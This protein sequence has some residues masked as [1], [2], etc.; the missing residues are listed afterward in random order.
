ME[1]EFTLFV[2]DDA[3]AVRRMI[4]SVFGK[5]YT[6]ESFASGAACLERLA[7]KVPGLFL[8]DVDMPEM[9]GYT[10]CRQIKDQPV[11]ANIPVIFISALD[12]LESRLAGYDAGGEE[13]IVKPY[14]VAELKKKIEVLRRI[15]QEKSALLSKL[16]E[17]D[18]LTS[19]VMSSLDE[20][21]ILVKFLRSLNRCAKYSEVGDAILSLLRSFHLD[22]AL[23]FRLPD[24]ELTL[25]LAGESNPLATAIISHV[26]TLGT[27]ASFKNRAVF[28]FD[29][30]SVLVNNMPLDDADLCGR[31]RDH[32]AIA[33]ET[34]DERLLTLLTR[35]E[36]SAT[37][38]EI[39]LLLE[40]LEAA[41]QGFGEKYLLARVVGSE[42]THAM[43]NELDAAFAS[44]GMRE[45]QEESIKEIIQSKTDQL[46]D[47]FDFG[48]ETEKALKDLSA[49][50]G[51]TLVAKS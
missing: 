10:L 19:L 32:L 42:A 41:I 27:V 36:S 33:V 28:N 4:E 20:Y 43:L 44:L 37:K 46:I 50:L 6:V 2:V 18:M 38:G 13:F 7:V 3:E 39:E 9:D 22:G 45:V 31:L 34:A 29:R 35:Q 8:L 12:D 15:G 21:A 17:S 14:K 5:I 49:R 11:L 30:L 24:F 25:N 23:Q 1:K 48:A 16:G 40:A 47:S 51:Q 26:R